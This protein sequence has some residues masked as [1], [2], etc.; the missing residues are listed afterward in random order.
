MGLCEPKDG[1]MNIGN[2]AEQSKFSRF[3]FAMGFIV[4]S[5]GF[6]IGAIAVWFLILR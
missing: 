2:S 3:H 4:L 6:Y 5:G 1:H